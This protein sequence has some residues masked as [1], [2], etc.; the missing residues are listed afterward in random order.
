MN[1]ALPLP[2]SSGQQ[3]RP[4]RR[5]NQTLAALYTLPAFRF[6]QI[7][8]YGLVEHPPLVVENLCG[9]CTEV[10]VT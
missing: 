10:V 2:T 7:W 6:A 8:L 9:T 3:A 1:R 5:L 4:I